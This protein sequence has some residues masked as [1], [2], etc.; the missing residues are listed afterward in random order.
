YPRILCASIRGELGPSVRFLWKDVGVSEEDL[1]R[2]L[3]TF[4]LLFAVPL[5]RMQDVVSFL[6]EDLTINKRDIAKI[7]RAFPSLLG[8]ERERHMSG[9]VKYLKKLG[10]QNVGRFVSRLPPVLGYDVNTNL[11]PKMDYLVE[12]MGLSV[13]DVLTFPAYFSYP[14]DTVIEPRTEFLIIR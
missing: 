9:V 3:Q 1:P 14:L 8:L 6:S 10:V 4:P 2:V 12:E 7:I 13:Y 11:A 5:V